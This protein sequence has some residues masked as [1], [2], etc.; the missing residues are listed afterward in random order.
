MAG[1]KN[2]KSGIIHGL[3]A[4]RISRDEADLIGAFAIGDVQGEIALQR[5]LIGRLAQVLEHNGLAPG[6]TRPLPEGTRET[7]KLLNQTMRDLLRFIHSHAVNADDLHLYQ[8]QIE[9]GKRLAR[10]RHDVFNYLEPPSAR[11]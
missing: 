9:S 11:S 6:S 4:K 2:S 10:K 3:Y 5:A 7:L 8:S 1:P